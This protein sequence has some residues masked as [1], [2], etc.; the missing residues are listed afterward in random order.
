[1]SGGAAGR[2]GSGSGATPSGSSARVLF[3]E[4]TAAPPWLRVVGVLALVAAVLLIVDAT[5][6]DPTSFQGGGAIAAVVAAIV[7]VLIGAVALVA[8]ISVV[9][10]GGQVAFALSPVWRLRF[11]RSDVGSA[12]SVDVVARDFGGPGYRVLP[13]NK[14][15]LLFTSGRGVTVVRRST[16]ITYTVRTERPADLV[17]A[18][19]RR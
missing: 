15:A 6:I 1:M 18:L 5:V 19:L 3:E 4:T 17:A 14:R 11:A 8:R 12:K 7:L 16:G 10:D 2:A 9:V 13:G